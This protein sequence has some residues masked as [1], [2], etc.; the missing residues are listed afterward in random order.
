MHA[1][2]A[3]KHGAAA[4]KEG[5]DREAAAKHLAAAKAH[6]NAANEHK[7]AGAAHKAAPGADASHA[8]SNTAREASWQAA[9]K[10]EQLFGKAWVESELTKI[11]DPEAQKA[12]ET[13]LDAAID[14]FVASFT[15]LNKVG[16]RNSAMDADR[17]QKCHDIMKELGASCSTMTDKAADVEDLR[18]NFEER[19]ALFKGQIEGL[20]STLEGLT[21]KVSE[22]AKLAAPARAAVFAV[23]KDVDSGAQPGEKPSPENVEAALEKMSPEERAK[24]LMKQSL[25]APVAL[26]WS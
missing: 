10:S 26:S 18:K 15:E 19:E 7:A 22:M 13:R 21:K 20:T 8:A 12:A 3:A 1:L 24:V 5:I 17:L 6:D 4:D 2:A 23:S 16:A 14:E 9:G 11:V 25:R